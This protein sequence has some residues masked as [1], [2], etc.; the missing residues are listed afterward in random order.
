MLEFDAD[1]N[2]WRYE[3]SLSTGVK[4]WSGDDR[5]KRLALESSGH[6]ELPSQKDL[7]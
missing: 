4:A 1:E 3:E 5:Q 2:Y 7:C 6:S